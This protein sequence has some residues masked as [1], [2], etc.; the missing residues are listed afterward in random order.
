[1]MTDQTKPAKPRKRIWLRVLF[2]LSLALNLLV[3]GLVAGAVMRFGA[4]GGAYPASRS[5]AALMLRELPHED[6]RALRQRSGDTSAEIRLRQQANVEALAQALRAVP[7]DPEA[8]DTLLQGLGAERATFVRAVQD[9]WLERVSRMS[10]R[11][12]Q[13]YADRLE[14]AMTHRSRR[15]NWWRN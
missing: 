6:R 4:T 9:S 3:V 7:F 2:G 13:A 10:D 12:R 15:R 11:G 5:I 14:Q 1:M 8:L